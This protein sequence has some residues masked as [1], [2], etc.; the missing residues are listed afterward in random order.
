MCSIL[1]G[2]LD[3]LGLSF[4]RDLLCLA[5]FICLSLSLYLPLSLS[6]PLSLSLSPSLPSISFMHE[7]V[8]HWRSP[9]CTTSSENLRPMYRKASTMVLRGFS[10]ACKIRKSHTRTLSPFLSLSLPTCVCMEKTAAIHSILGN[11]RCGRAN[12]GTYCHSMLLPRRGKYQFCSQVP[13]A[14]L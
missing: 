2:V 4:A 11:V 5:E 3:C 1:V 14:I 13:V 12:F 9:A 10:A 7:H 6:H 8:Q